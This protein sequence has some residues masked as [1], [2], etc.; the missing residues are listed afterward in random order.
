MNGIKRHPYD[1]WF[2]EATQGVAFSAEIRSW[3]ERAYERGFIDGAK[4]NA[5]LKV[6][7]A[8]DRTMSTFLSKGPE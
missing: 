1:I 4:Y 6:S 3:M 2:D 8:L 7:K 5:E